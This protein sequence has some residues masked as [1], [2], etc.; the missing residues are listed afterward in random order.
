MKRAATIILLIALCL[1]LFSCGS[2][3]KPIKASKDDLR[4]VATVLGREIKYD[5]T[6]YLAYTYKLDME[7]IY[8]AGIWDAPTA[9]HKE[10]L[11]AKIESVLAENAALLAFYD[12]YDIDTESSEAEKSV[13]AYIDQFAGELGGADAYKKY[14]EESRMTDRYL[15]YILS[16]EVCREKLRQALISDGKIDSSDEAFEAAIKSDEFVRTLHV[17]IGNDEG[18]DVEENRKRAEKVVELLDSGEPM[19]RM[20]GRYSEDIYMTTTD[21]YYFM[22]GEYEKAYEEAACGLAVGEYSGVVEGE[23]CF[24]VI[25]RLP[26]EDEYIE[27]NYESLKDRYLYVMFDEIVDEKTS[28]AEI[29]YTD[30]GKGLDFSALD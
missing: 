27:K 4:T 7:S 30:F 23:K 2:G 12:E 8:G 13:R 6:R 3:I 19:T 5:E 26:K 22:R 9:E 20:I 24:Y 16:I 18:D 29:S 21:G 15:R 14:L 25:M 1:S 10:E 11:E 17:Y 28:G